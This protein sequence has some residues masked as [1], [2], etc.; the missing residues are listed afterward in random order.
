[1]YQGFVRGVKF[2]LVHVLAQSA[3]SLSQVLTLST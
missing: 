1:M 2:L 3:P